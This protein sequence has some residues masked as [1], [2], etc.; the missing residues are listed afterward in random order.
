[1]Q[2]TNAGVSL[3]QCEHEGGCHIETGSSCLGGE[4]LGEMDFL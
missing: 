1:M 3:C 2:E 4:Q